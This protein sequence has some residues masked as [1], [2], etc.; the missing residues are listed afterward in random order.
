MLIL[1]PLVL[2]P[3]QKILEQDETSLSVE[4][5]NKLL[6][7][8]S[9]Q[10]QPPVHYREERRDEAYVDGLLASA[11]FAFGELVG[12]GHMSGLLVRRDW[13]L[14]LMKSD[15]PGSDQSSEL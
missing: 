8:V 3:G 5:N 1:S 10:R 9:R 7:K 12:C 2:L 15:E 6:T 13:L 14:A 11:F 4:S